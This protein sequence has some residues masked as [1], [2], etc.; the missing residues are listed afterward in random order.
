M[1]LGVGHGWAAVPSLGEITRLKQVTLRPPSSSLHPS[2]RR[3]RLEN[4]PRVQPRRSPG[5]GRR[6]RPG[7]PTHPPL[8]PATRPGADST[9]SPSRVGE[10]RLREVGSLADSGKAWLPLVPGPLSGSRRPGVCVPPPAP[11]RPLSPRAAVQGPGKDAPGGLISVSFT[12]L[13]VPRGHQ[14]SHLRG[15]RTRRGRG[16][17]SSARRPHPRGPRLPET[18]V[19][20]GAGRGAPPLAGPRFDQKPELWHR[21][22][23]AALPVT[24]VPATRPRG[25]PEEQA[26]WERRPRFAQA[27]PG[28]QAWDPETSPPTPHP[29]H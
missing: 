22:Q 20:L 9:R 27:P 25:V 11:A 18:T 8:P 17:N 16:R 13:R 1:N 14:R 6:R 26:S 29:P 15:S 19:R 23:P 7:T 4:V 5:G 3:R 24:P 2:S 28:L 10:P 21:S 12:G